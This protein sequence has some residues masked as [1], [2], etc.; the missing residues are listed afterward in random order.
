MQHNSIIRESDLHIIEPKQS[1]LGSVIWLHGLGA[2]NRNFDPLVPALTQHGQLPLR[3]IFPNAPIRPVSINNQYPMRAWYDVYSLTHLDRE[4]EMGIAESQRYLE[5]LIDTEVARGIPTHQI[6]L[7]GFSQ[8]GAMVLHTGLRYPKPLAGILALSCYLPLFHQLTDH[9][10]D[11]NQNT[12]IFIAHGTDD[13]ILS[14]SD[15]KIT[16][17]IL[18]H[19]HR[20]V[21]WR[22]Y[23]MAHEI[24]VEEVNDITRWLAEIFCS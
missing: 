7:A 3:F 14:A 2:D 12:P 22:E 5:K 15:A 8:G 4:D 13:D 16:H 11:A 21:L 24:T 20:N 19:T 6:I 1:P 23:P 10:S 9:A 18:D 17:S